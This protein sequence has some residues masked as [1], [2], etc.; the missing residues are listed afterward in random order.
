MEHFAHAQTERDPR[1]SAACA[2]EPHERDDDGSLRVNCQDHEPRE[3]TRWIRP[4]QEK[5]N[6]D[7]PPEDSRH[8]VRPIPEQAGEP[9]DEKKPA[10]MR[11]G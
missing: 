9:P 3:G 8:I 10:P 6:I 1:A 4:R 2:I 5:D 11:A 7:E